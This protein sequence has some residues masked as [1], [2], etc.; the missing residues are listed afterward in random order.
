MTTPEQMRRRAAQQRKRRMARRACGHCGHQAEEMLDWAGQ[1]IP[2]YSACLDRLN[3]HIPNWPLL[4]HRQGLRC[5]IR[6]ERPCYD[7]AGGDGPSDVEARRENRRWPFGSL[8]R[9]SC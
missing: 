6:M 3:G 7:C 2:I 9:R 1:Q 4:D 8:F 5:P